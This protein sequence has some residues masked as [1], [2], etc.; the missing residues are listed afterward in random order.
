MDGFFNLHNNSEVGI[1][2]YTFKYEVKL[3]LLSQH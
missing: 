2:F 3:C 1:S